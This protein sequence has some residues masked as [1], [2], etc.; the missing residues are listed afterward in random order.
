LHVDNICSSLHNS[1]SN[2]KCCNNLNVNIL[3]YVQYITHSELFAKIS[4]TNYLSY[5][6]FDKLV[7]IDQMLYNVS[8]IASRRSF[9]TVNSC[10]LTF[11]LIIEHVVDKFFVNSMCITCDKLAELKLNKSDDNHCVS[12]LS[13]RKLNKLCNACAI[14]RKILFTC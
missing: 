14:E 8:M 4:S 5:I 6:I 2:F 13:S 10:K 7:E 3:H 11:N 9:N 1:Y 12:Y